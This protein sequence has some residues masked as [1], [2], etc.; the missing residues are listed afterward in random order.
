MGT[1]E[2]R[3]KL[4]A[5]AELVAR[6]INR[7]LS[8]FISEIV[9]TQRSI[10]ITLDKESDNKEAKKEMSA[11][12]K[13]VKA[14]NY[15]DAVAAYGK[16]YAAYKNFAAG[17]NHAVLTEAAMGTEVAVELIE[18]PARRNRRLKFRK[19]SRT[20]KRTRNP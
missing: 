16:I 7:P 18:E 1:T 17:Y 10:S 5:P 19:V 14:K 6:I 15:A 4:P 11:A 20:S 2:E 12:E 3:A 8:E 13:L 9:P